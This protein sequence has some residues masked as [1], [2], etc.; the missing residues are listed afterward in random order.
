MWDT[1]ESRDHSLVD[2]MKFWYFSIKTFLPIMTYASTPLEQDLWFEA[3]VRLCMM[4]RL[5]RSRTVASPLE[6]KRILPLKVFPFTSDLEETQGLGQ[7]QN[8][9]SYY[10]FFLT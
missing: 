4:A 10:P 8:L 1:N 5:S 7:T 6:K 3:E 9:S 2:V